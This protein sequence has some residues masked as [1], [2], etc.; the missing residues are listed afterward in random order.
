MNFL[1]ILKLAKY[2]LLFYL[3]AFNLTIFA[4]PVLLEQTK[5][6][7]L[8]GLNLDILKDSKKEYSYQEILEGKKDELFY[9][10]NVL[11]PNYGFQSSTYWVK[12]E[13]QNNSSEDRWILEVGFPIITN[14]T[15]FVLNEDGSIQTDHAGIKY[16]F[17][18]R[19]ILN[20]KF[21][22]PIQIT[23]NSKKK[24]LL[25]FED[26]GIMNLPIRV[27]TE[28]FFH[29][30]DH[31]EYLVLSLYYGIMIAMTLYNLFL[32]LSIRDKTYIFYC[33]FLMTS[34]LYFLSQNGLGYEFIWS[35]SPTIALR[36]NQ[37]SVSFVILFAIIY[38]YYFLNCKT[39]IPKIK[40]IFF[41]MG[42]IAI[43]CTILLY[44]TDQFYQ[45]SGRLISLF[46]I[47]VIL[48]V[49]ITSLKAYQRNYKPAI[50]FI[51]SVLVLFVGGIV[52]TLRTFGWI[53][54]NLVTNNA[55][56]FGS[57]LEAI[58]LSFGLADRINTLKQE[59]LKAEETTNAKSVFLA[60]M[61]HE[62]RTPMNGL[63][64]MTELLEKT[65]LDSK[66]KDLLHIIKESSNSLLAIINDILDYS[67]IES[68]KMDIE[69]DIF[70]LENCLQDSVNFFTQQARAKN[71]DIFYGMESSVPKVILGDQIRLRQIL[72]NLISNAIKFT[73]KGEIIVFAKLL[74][75]KDNIVTI[76]LSVKDTGIGIPLERRGK[77][78][79]PFT[80][81][82]TSTTR[83][84]GGTG[85]GLAICSRL[86]DLMEGKIWIDP[87]VT[88]GTKICFT[89]KIEEISE[90][91]YSVIPERNTFSEDTTLPIEKENIRILVVD[92]STINQIVI[93]EM[94]LSFGFESDLVKNGL[95]ALNAIQTKKYDIVFMDVFMPEM[96]GLT[97][98]KNIRHEQKED[99]LFIIAMTANATAE[100]REE[101]ISAGMDDYI[102]KPV[103]LNV[104]RTKTL[105]WASKVTQKR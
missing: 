90:K 28:N 103:P 1:S 39:I 83:R 86:V 100:D 27:Y 14:I 62:I 52:Y 6:N 46:G 70:N 36:I 101:C 7:Y 2:S 20:R 63:I 74:E 5:G 84:F 51:I 23:K 4:E 9:R 15:L 95:E 8:L 96:D 25:C 44:F 60:M 43:I 38:A 48:T 75:K 24:I 21:L 11:T 87:N 34:S 72:I 18:Q 71:I 77:L 29:S 105:Y 79:Q 104:L 40:P 17:N 67:K 68:G 93:Q 76:E 65:N 45:I 94:L 13:L 47:I 26:K 78:F 59:K 54:S 73:E 57:V 99:T 55:M 85:L 88:S 50:Y 64:G 3:L 35:N 92:D 33:L 89:I 22:F 82:D 91:A 97:A 49:F 81:L 12:I 80:Q 31:H 69:K 102:S 30:N 53:E 66:Q 41:S 56:Q 58:L 16:P 19:K 98:T 37:I 32:F 61:S 10:S 42:L